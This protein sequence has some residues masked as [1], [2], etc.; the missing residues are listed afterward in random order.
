MN[1][2]LKSVFLI[3][4]LGLSLFTTSASASIVSLVDNFDIETAQ[5]NQS[6]FVNFNVINGT[7]DT[8]S[9]GGF[10]ITCVGGSGVCIDLDG[11]TGDA[12][13][14]ISKEFFAAGAYLLQFAISGNQRNS[15][16][17]SVFVS[18]GDF[19]EVFELTGFADFMFIERLVNV[20]AMG[21]QLIFA[22]LGADNVGII[23]DNVSVELSTVPVPAAFWLFGSALIGFMGL[24]K[25][26]TN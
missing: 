25:R 5:L 19:T 1:T 17:D 24:R 13:E 7:V 26:K 12:G 16:S 8:I 21:S 3:A 14:L 9:S 10:G 11:S 4:L 15:G 20:D 22:D 23:L 2:Y 18:L 6:T